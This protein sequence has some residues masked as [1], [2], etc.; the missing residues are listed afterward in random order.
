MF[1]TL[2]PLLVTIGEYRCVFFC[3]FDK[4]PLKVYVTTKPVY[5]PRWNVLLLPELDKRRELA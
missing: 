2:L 1:L 3:Q 4:Y 5:V